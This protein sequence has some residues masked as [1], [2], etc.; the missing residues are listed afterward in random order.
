MNLNWFHNFTRLTKPPFLIWVLFLLSSTF[1]CVELKAFKGEILKEVD[2]YSFRNSI[3]VYQFDSL[4]RNHKLKSKSNLGLK[5]RERWFLYE[6]QYNGNPKDIVI[7]IPE[8]LVDDVVGYMVN[9]SGKIEYFLKAGDEG[10][11]SQKKLKIR[12]PAGF[13]RLDQK[14]NTPFM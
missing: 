2:Y 13:Y 4:Y 9:P 1:N 7:E 3:D 14:G 8:T 11:L 6:F 10:K 12:T 5:D